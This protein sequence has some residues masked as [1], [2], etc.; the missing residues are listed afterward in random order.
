MPLTLAET[1]AA[2]S[3][4]PQVAQMRVIPIEGIEAKPLVGESW[5]RPW[6]KVIRAND[7]FRKKRRRR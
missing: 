3:A 5:A 6:A 4:E 7:L 2:T 1:I